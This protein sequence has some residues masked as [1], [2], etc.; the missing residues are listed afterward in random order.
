VSPLLAPSIGSFITV[1]LGWRWIFVLLVAIVVAVLAMIFLYLP[2]GHEPDPT[3]SL[4]PRPILKIFLS[5]LSEPRFFTYAVAGALSFSGLFAYLASSPV[6]FLNIFPLGPKLYGAVFALLASGMIG[7]SQ[8]N[9]FLMRKFRSEDLFSWALIAQTVISSAFLLCSL[10]MEIS[11]VTMIVLLFANMFAVGLGSPN[12]SALSLAPFTRNVGSA[13]ALMGFL[14]I[15]AGAVVTG[16]IGMLNSARLVP[17]AL[18]FAASAWLALLVLLIGK[19]K[20]S[21]TSPHNDLSHAG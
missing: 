10:A 2:E 5:I 16:F 7:A 14:Q 1:T 12:G 11:L 13:S 21:E 9:I 6:I 8:V 20:F 4:R 15:G 18:V 19:R 17:I 3:I